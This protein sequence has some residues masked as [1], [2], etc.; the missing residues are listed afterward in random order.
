MRAIDR[1]SESSEPYSLH[2]AG[3]HSSKMAQI[4]TRM[5]GLRSSTSDGH[6]TA[7]RSESPSLGVELSHVH[8]D[9]VGSRTGEAAM[10]RPSAKPS[11]MP[12]P[13]CFDTSRPSASF[14]A[15]LLVVLT[16]AEIVS[17]V[18][19]AGI[20]KKERAKKSCFGDV[21]SI[22]GGA[23]ALPPRSSAPPCS[24]CAL[25]SWPTVFRRRPTARLRDAPFSAT[26]DASTVCIRIS[27]SS[28]LL[29]AFATSSDD[30]VFSRS[31][32]MVYL[33]TN[34]RPSFARSDEASDLFRK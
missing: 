34:C 6:V 11:A 10:R 4:S 14:E 12:S 26:S 29:R 32:C 18:V 8:A 7:R 19:R 30:S 22:V 2:A 25:C 21:S 13:V 23:R 15:M 3:A 28:L 1:I 31:C 16:A 33:R 24:R 27:S 9:E 17:F 5:I 20:L